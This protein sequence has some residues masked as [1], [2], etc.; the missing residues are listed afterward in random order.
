[1]W[2]QFVVPRAAWLHCFFSPHGHVLRS[3]AN[4]PNGKRGEALMKKLEAIIRHE[5]LEKVRDALDKA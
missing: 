3:G 1:M 2:G 4:A 5:L